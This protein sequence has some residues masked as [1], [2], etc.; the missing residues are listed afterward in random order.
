MGRS[1]LDATAI[2]KPESFSVLSPPSESGWAYMILMP[3]LSAS[4]YSGLMFD[5]VNGGEHQKQRATGFAVSN[6]SAR[7]I[8]GAR[9][10]RGNVARVSHR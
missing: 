1:F 3:V 2:L 10:R 9:G 8:Y 6:L 7:Q 5:P 4:T